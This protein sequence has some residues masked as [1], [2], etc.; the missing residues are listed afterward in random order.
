MIV[1]I[2]GPAGSGKSTIA[3][4]IAHR[5]G[6]EK[7]DTGA[8]YRTVA[9]ACVR[10]GIDLDDEAAVCEQARSI[11]ISFDSTGSI[12]RIAL[13]DDDVSDAI[14]TPE[15]DRIVSKVSAYPG[16]R[17]AMLPVQRHFAEGRNVVAEGRDIGTV[18]F[19][20]AAVKVF[21]T[22]D[23]RERSRR[24]VLQRHEGETVSSDQLEREVEET[25]R[26]LERRDALDSSRE[27]A[28]LK[29]ADDAVRMDSS[30]H[31]IDEVVD[32]ISRLID[33]RGE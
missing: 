27:T 10:D 17:E 4:E 11:R 18:V 14:R 16:V 3:H 30:G 23:P 20:H 6:F 28:P 29:A 26:D 31:T 15:V 19:P 32:A 1:A 24:R 22:A 2:D 8:L 5:R 12:T 33:E 9:L 25:L 13:D 7:L 21:L